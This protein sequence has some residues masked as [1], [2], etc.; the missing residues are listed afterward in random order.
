MDDFKVKIDVEQM[1]CFK[2]E[3]PTLTLND[4]IVMANTA[5]ND[6]DAGDTCK[7]Y[8]GTG[9][10]SNFIY[11][12]A[13][14]SV[15][16]SQFTSTELYFDGKVCG[17]DAAYD[18]TS[19]TLVYKAKL[20]TYIHDDDTQVLFNPAT[21]AVPITCKYTPSVDGEAIA[22]DSLVLDNPKKSGTTKVEEAAEAT[23]FSVT[24]AVSIKQP[25]GSYAP[26]DED[27]KVM[28]GE[29]VKVTF[30]SSADL[31]IHIATCT[32]Q[33]D[34]T[35]PTNTL[36]IVQDDCFLTKTTGDAALE[37]VQPTHV[38]SAV[39]G[40]TAMTMNQFAFID[41]NS[42]SEP[43]P[44]LVFHMKCKIEIGDEECGSRRRRRQANNDFI[45][46]TYEINSTRHNYAV[47]DGIVHLVETTSASLANVV[48]FV[49]IIVT[50]MFL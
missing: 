12:N 27:D 8:G 34:A 21:I 20:G 15:A 22:L 49:T 18:A 41:A 44:D 32:G 39:S 2:Q 9:A 6:V 37:Y 14:L 42:A 25:D 38:A 7:A 31:A 11:S 24:A 23:A 5:E 47:D 30:T 45:D 43:N 40:V 36:A 35:T 13:D 3:Y 28:L 46:V 16:V 50:L 33:D 17:A 4:L 29:E 19:N 1:D 10:G 48:S 26:L